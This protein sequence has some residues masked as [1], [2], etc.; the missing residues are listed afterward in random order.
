MRINHNIAAL[1]TYRQLGSAINAQQNQW[2]NYL[3]VFVLTMQEMMQQVLQSLKKC[4]RQVRGLD[5]GF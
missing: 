1:N 5:H 2:R 4:V 3:Q